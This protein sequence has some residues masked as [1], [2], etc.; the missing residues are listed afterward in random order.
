MPITPLGDPHTVMEALDRDDVSF[1]LTGARTILVAQGKMY[2]TQSTA[3]VL[4]RNNQLECTILPIGFPSDGFSQAEILHIEG[5]DA[6]GDVYAFIARATSWVSSAKAT[7]FNGHVLQLRAEKPEASHHASVSARLPASLIYPFSSG[8]TTKR[9][10]G[11]KLV[12]QHSQFDG[13]Y[14]ETSGLHIDIDDRRSHNVLTVHVNSEVDIAADALKLTQATHEAAV[15]ALGTLLHPDYFCVYDKTKRIVFMSA[16]RAR[17]SFEQYAAPVDLRTEAERFANLFAKTFWHSVMA[18]T[19]GRTRVATLVFDVY[20]TF[21]GGHIDQQLLH[22]CI[23]IENLLRSRDALAAEHRFSA[24]DR[25]AIDN[26]IQASGLPA[27]K[28]NRL[29]AMLTQLNNA[30]ISYLFDRAIGSRLL[31]DRHKVAWKRNRSVLAHGGNVSESPD[32]QS[33]DRIVLLEGFHQLVG[34]EIL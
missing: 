20:K 22:L 1:V 25:R 27:D 28:V 3:Q 11:N 14:Y 8:S 5:V 12:G 13:Y 30:S 15:Y 29:K 9:T 6:H 16:T 18:S 23:A 4:T 31:K 32:V 19:P 34:R 21:D 7:A 33:V 2:E 10:W 26:S 17:S 24:D